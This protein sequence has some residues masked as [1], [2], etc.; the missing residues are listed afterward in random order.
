MESGSLL[1][2]VW[3]FFLNIMTEELFIISKIIY[4]ILALKGEISNVCSIMI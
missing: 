3:W 2:G 1:F 4:K